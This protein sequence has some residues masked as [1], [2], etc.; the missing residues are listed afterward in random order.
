MSEYPKP[1]SKKCTQKILE[2]MNNNLFDIIKDTHQICFFIKIKNNNLQIPA[3]I[4]NYNIINY[5]TNN[6]D[7]NIYINNEINKIEL[8]KGKYFNKDYS[9]AIIE[10]KENKKINYL[11]LDDNLFIDEYENYYNKESIYIFNYNKNDIEV[12]YSIINNINN[13]EIIFPCYL[14]KNNNHI[15]PI[16]NINNNKLIGIKSNN[17]KYYN[18][19]LLFI[20]IINEFIDKNKEKNKIENNKWNEINILMSINENDKNHKIYI[21]NKDINNA[22]KLNEINSELYINNI[23]KIYKQYFVPEKKGE[24]NIKLKFNINLTDCCSMFENCKNII[25]I[26]FIYFNTSYVKNMNHMFHGCINLN[27]LDLSSFN[28]KN[29]TD[30]SEMF[31]HCYILNNLDLSSF[32]TKNVTDMSRMFYECN[33]LNKLNLSSFNTKKVLD[34]SYMFHN[35]KNLN[36]LDLSSF[37]TKK[38]L[39]MSD[40]F[41]GCRY[42][43]NLDLSS[44]NTKNVSDMSFMFYECKNLENLDLSSF[45]IKKFTDMSF[46]FYGCKNLINLDLSSFGKKITNII[47]LNYKCSDSIYQPNKSTFK[48]F[49]KEELE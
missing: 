21:L 13:S 37:D 2:Q 40:M 24:Y 29:V 16:F 48:K 42:L 10:I 43:N 45:D 27:N 32:D 6:N 30:M 36:N 31:S 38:V 39:D 4:T 41:S 28:T 22:T 5:M 17:Y 33:N 7:I 44:F 26:N 8:G 3:M 25:Q 12:S 11:E 19:G 47:G 18:K 34:M 46:M 9:L 1:I 35:C 23:K 15:L 14:N 49:K 20:F